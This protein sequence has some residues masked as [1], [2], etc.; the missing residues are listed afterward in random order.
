MKGE[1]TLQLLPHASIAAC[2][3]RNFDAGIA[4]GRTFSVVIV[5]YPVTCGLPF[6]AFK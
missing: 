4:L 2:M 1:E 3:L 5:P 6:I